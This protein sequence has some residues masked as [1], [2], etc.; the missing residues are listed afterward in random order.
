MFIL[1]GSQQFNLM[2]GVTQSLAGRT[3]IFKLFPFNISELGKLN[4]PNI[5]QTLYKGFYPRIWSSD[6]LP[7]T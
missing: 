7:V 3:A 1:S 4:E 6:V 2:S 5:N